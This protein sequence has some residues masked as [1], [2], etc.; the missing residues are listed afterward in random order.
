MMAV[1]CA[2]LTATASS[3]LAVA[4]SSATSGICTVNGNTVTLQGSAGSCTIVATQSGNSSFMPAA[5]VT[6]TIAVG[7]WVIAVGNPYGLGG[8]VTSGILSAR[9]RDIGAGP[10]DDFLQTDAPINPGNSGG[11][12]FNLRGEVVGINS[13]IYSRTGGYQGLSFA[14]PIDVAMNAVGQNDKL[15][16]QGA[17]DAVNMAIEDFQPAK[18]GMSV[19]VV[20]ADSQN[21]P[22]ISTTIVRRSVS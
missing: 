8:T 18:K 11:P 15:I 5:P 17:V 3:G 1:R 21:K 12:L 7:D 10:F 13:Q 16:A 4:Y 22:D 14:I 9:G 6:R 2:A 19:E 20:S